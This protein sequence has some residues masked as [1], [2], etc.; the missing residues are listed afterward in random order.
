MNLSS[1][2]DGEWIAG[3]GPE[4]VN[5]NPARP[6]EVVASYREVACDLVD[7]A[8]DAAARSA[9]GWRRTSVHQ[10]A[11]VLDG[12]G[13]LLARRREDL[14]RELSQEEGKPLREGIAEVDRAARIFR[15]YAAEAD[16]DVGAVFAS[17]RPSERVYT[18]QVP[19]GPVA[20]V[21]PWN[22]PIAIPA[23]KLAP[24]LVYGNT[25]VWKPSP[26]TPK[27]AVRLSEVLLEAGLPDG[28]LNVVLG[29]ADTA[30]RLLERPTIRA[31]SFTGS[32]A[33]GRSVVA[34][35]ARRGL[36]VQAEMGGINVAVVM[37]DADL[38]VAAQAIV[39][40][41][42]GSTG[43]KCTATSRVLVDGAVH[44]ELLERIVA[45]CRA[46][47]VGDPLDAD[48]DLGPVATPGQLQTIRAAL[49]DVGGGRSRVLLDGDPARD[50]SAGYFV[51]PSI[52]DDADGRH[53]VSAEE[54]FGPV[55]AVTPVHG[56][57][58]AFAEVNAGEFG[59]S[60]SVFTTDLATAELAP[61]CLD[62][63]VLHINSE[64]TGAE[65]HV[66]FG[67]MKASGWGGREQGRAARDFYTETRTV[68]VS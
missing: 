61:E 18:R 54:V 58:A 36:K 33:V 41:A 26:V 45:G 22:F 12:A 39:Q 11:A 17:A 8:A 51:G 50:P 68:Y 43:Q 20:L 55:V 9:M 14:G 23:W 21:T 35:A 32:T 28:V 30:R 2:V 42:M 60:A 15:Y 27:L 25:V 67:G 24:A 62:V 31:C 66:P 49:D 59:L 6:Q 64:T 56:R 46:L 34:S 19:V 65:P 3:S 38:D 7:L 63:G 16:R 10:R 47:R 5:R 48:T 52:I 1:M 44:G 37:A 4:I 53:R 29:G 40:G 57:D 13:D